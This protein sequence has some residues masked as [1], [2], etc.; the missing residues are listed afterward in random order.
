MKHRVLEP[1]TRTFRVVK[2]THLDVG[3]AGS[4]LNL[5]LLGVGFGPSVAGGGGLRLGSRAAAA[6]RA[7]LPMRRGG[8]RAAGGAQAADAGQSGG[9]ARPHA[10]GG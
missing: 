10:A 9:A 6:L 7:S 8:A 2:V 1:Q 5:I 3:D 4:A